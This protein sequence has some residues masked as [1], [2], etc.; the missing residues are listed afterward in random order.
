MR[1]TLGSFICTAAL[2]AALAPIAN[3]AT[4]QQTIA[5]LNAQRAANGIPAGITENSTWS[6]DCMAHDQYMQEN[7][8][9]LT[10][11]EVPGNPGYSTGG[12]FAGDNAVLAEGTNWDAGNPYEYAPLHLDQLLA[13]ALEA[14]GTA[15]FDGFSCTTTFPGWTRPAPSSLE[16][17]TYPGQG[18]AIYPSEVADE[19]PFTPGSLVGLNLGAR[20][21][22][23]LFVFVAAPNQSP[24]ANPAS[25]SQATLTGPS[26]TVAVDTVDGDTRI[27]GGSSSGCPSGTLTCYIAS[28]GF[29]IPVKP[30][31]GSATYHAHVVVGFAGTQTA[32]DWTFTTRGMSPNSA[33]TVTGHT[34]RFRSSSPAP[35]RV[36]FTRATGAHAPTAKLYPGQ[37][38]RLRLS[39]GSWQACG[40]QRASGKYM[41]FSECVSILITGVPKLSFGK[42]KLTPRGVVFAL[43]Y[44][45]VLRGRAAMLTVTP[46]TVTCVAHHGCTSTAGTPTTR[47]LTLRVSSV[48]V[49]APAKGDG[50]RL[51]IA[52]T[53]FQLRDAPWLAAHAT[54][55]AFVSP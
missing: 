13:P 1:R 41:S 55:R 53:A 16:I 14:V 10:H 51:T 52:T 39:P 28:G 54:S 17:Y 21:G 38:Y 8:D 19:Q 24:T 23:N 4:A 34:L 18:A 3:A 11:V 31:Q 49:P 12:N 26:G 5:T 43:Y 9:A 42:P 22:P 6:Q 15:D 50:V 46:L 37:H 2:V 36:T 47:S 44:S 7:G 32:H 33:L 27:P 29:I 40:R 25:L 20:T 48:T 45:G 35:I 30:L